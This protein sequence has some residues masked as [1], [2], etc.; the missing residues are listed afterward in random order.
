KVPLEQVANI[1]RTFPKAWLS[2]SKIDVTDDFLRYAQ[3]LIGTKW[4]KIPLEK[5][6]QRFTRFKPIFAEK[7]C[8][9]YKP[10]VYT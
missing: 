5:G 10:E 4:V 8:L 7:Q 3:P 1:E 9:A 2:P 6:I